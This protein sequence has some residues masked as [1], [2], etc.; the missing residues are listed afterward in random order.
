M[1]EIQSDIICP[2][3]GS[4]AYLLSSQWEYYG[5]CQECDWGYHW[6]LQRDPPNPYDQTI[7]S[8]ENDADNDI[9]QYATPWQKCMTQH[10]MELTGQKPDMHN[11][12]FDL[13]GMW[14][15]VERESAGVGPPSEERNELWLPRSFEPWEGD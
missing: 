15:F 11:P 14:R 4:R 5:H 7:P 12:C 6:I 1:T 8:A 10:E 3:C 2:A 9:T 13:P